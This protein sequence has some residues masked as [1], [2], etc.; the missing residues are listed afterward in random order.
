M[1]CGEALLLLE[2]ELGLLRWRLGTRLDGALT[3]PLRAGQRT[4]GE[5]AR[6]V[7]LG[8]RERVGVNEAR[9]VVHAVRLRGLAEVHGARLGVVDAC[10]LRCREG[11]SVA[12]PEVGA[13]GRLDLWRVYVKAFNRLY[14]S[15]SGHVDARMDATNGCSTPALGPGPGAA[16]RRE[17]S[18]QGEGQ[19]EGAR[20]DIHRAT[21]DG[22]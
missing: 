1:G 21:Y 5:A 15:V 6:A 13:D 20:T 16:Q 9:R 8:V 7:H 11:R 4:H 19:G 2:A 3:I 14:N 22:R 18:A 17:G 10:R 12:V